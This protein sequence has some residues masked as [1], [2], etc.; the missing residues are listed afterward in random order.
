MLFA[1]L[2]CRSEP[3][4]VSARKVR[5]EPAAGARG[6]A[7]L[8]SDRGKSDKI[9]CDWLTDHIVNACAAGQPLNPRGALRRVHFHADA[10]GG[11]VY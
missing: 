4:V 9:V 8:A 5:A 11:G 2:L 1:C 3:R 7:L 10:H 6:V